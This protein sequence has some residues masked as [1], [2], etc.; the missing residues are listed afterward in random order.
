MHKDA[1]IHI[2]MFVYEHTFIF[3]GVNPTA[4]VLGIISSV[5]STLAGLAD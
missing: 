4:Y 1:Y 2:Y 3:K 5:T